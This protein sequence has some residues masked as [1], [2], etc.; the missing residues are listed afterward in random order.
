MNTEVADADSRGKLGDPPPGGIGH[1]RW[2]NGSRDSGLVVR[3]GGV[4]MDV[5]R[6]KEAAYTLADVYQ[7]NVSG[8]GY[9][10]VVH[11]E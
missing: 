11:E 4:E 1:Y 6:V 3:F 8:G 7:I 9:C 5:V 2:G 10:G